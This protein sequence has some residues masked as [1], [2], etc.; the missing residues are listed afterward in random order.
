VLGAIPMQTINVFAD[1]SLTTLSHV[2]P[3]CVV[4]V[5]ILVSQTMNHFDAIDGML[6]PSAATLDN[7]ETACN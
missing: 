7:M 6:T 1:P 4:L 3:P 2:H 5:I